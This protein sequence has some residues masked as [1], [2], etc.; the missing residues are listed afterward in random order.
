M[1]KN[2]NDD[3]VHHACYLNVALLLVVKKNLIS[4]TRK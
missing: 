2:L 4:V 3:I 1:L